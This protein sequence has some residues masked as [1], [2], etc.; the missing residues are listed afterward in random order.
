[1]A[2]SC[3]WD[4][5]RSGGWNICWWHRAQS[6]PIQSLPILTGNLWDSDLLAA[7]AVAAV[8]EGFDLDDVI[9]L[10]GQGQLH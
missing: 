5:I 4:E 1:M 2:E 9:L 7:A 6:L 8:A 10:K 3:F